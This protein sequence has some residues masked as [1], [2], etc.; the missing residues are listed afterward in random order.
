MDGSGDDPKFAA[1]AGKD[2]QSVVKVLF[3]MGRRVHHPDPGAAAR[4][5]GE[6]TR[7]CTHHKR[8]PRVIRNLAYMLYPDALGAMTINSLISPIMMGMIGVSVRP[9]SKPS[10][11]ILVLK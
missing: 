8:R 10:F 9:V 2:F 11:W 1:Y 3:G 4:H 7:H 6:T 5:G